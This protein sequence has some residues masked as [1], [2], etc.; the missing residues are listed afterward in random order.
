M[1]VARHLTGVYGDKA[2]S[3]ANIASLTGMRWPILGRKLHPEFPF[4]EAEVSLWTTESPTCTL[5]LLV[6]E[7]HLFGRRLHCMPSDENLL[8]IICGRERVFTSSLWNAYTWA[9]SYALSRITVCSRTSR[10]NEVQA[11]FWIC[12]LR[13]E[14]PHV[15]P[16]TGAHKI[17]GLLACSRGTTIGEIKPQNHQLPN[18]SIFKADSD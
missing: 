3:I 12:T 17:E 4:I 5:S 10:N 8:W 7:S 2:V 1:D 15:C 18:V 14:R 13:S 9:Y 16:F 6:R 11:H